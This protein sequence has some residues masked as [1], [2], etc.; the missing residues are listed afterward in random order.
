MEQRIETLEAELQMTRAQV[1]MHHALLIGVLGVL[2]ADQ[3]KSVAQVM[4]AAYENALP[5][6]LASSAS[7]DALEYAERLRE[8][9]LQTLGR[10]A[11]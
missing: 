10:S 2:T 6:W 11:P 1:G 4:T 8:I 3:K 9:F 7:A 5:H